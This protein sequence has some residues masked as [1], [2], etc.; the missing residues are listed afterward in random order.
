MPTKKSST[1]RKTAKPTAKGKGKRGNAKIP[2]AAG[3]QK[4]ARGRRVAAQPVRTEFP[5]TVAQLVNRYHQEVCRGGD[6][7]VVAYSRPQLISQLVK[8]SHGD[9]RIYVEIGLL[10][11]AMDPEI[12]GRFIVW[13]KARGSVRDAEVAFPVLALRGLTREDFA[14]AENAVAHLMQLSPIDLL[15]AYQLNKEL[16]AAGARITGGWRKEL[17]EPAL[18]RYLQA[19]EASQNWWD[20]TALQF[21]DELRKLYRIAHLQPSPRAKAILFENSVPA[22]SV[23]AALRGLKDMPPEDAAGAILKH[24]I[25]LQ[26]AMGAL[27]RNLADPT[28]VFALIRGMTHNQLVNNAVLLEKMGVG[29]NPL[30]TAA[31]ENAL[32][33]AIS[34]KG[35][36]SSGKVNT[37]KA[38][39]AAELV[40]DSRIASKLVT[41]QQKSTER[42]GG[43]EGDWL[44]LVD[45]SQSMQH[46]IGVGTEFGALIA[47]R[48]KGKVQLIFFNHDIMPVDITGLTLDQ[49]KRKV[50]KVIAVGGTNIGKG[51][52][53]LMSKGEPV[54]GI[55]I[56]SDGGD[57]GAAGPYMG[58]QT[59]P[60]FPYVYKDYCE[61]LGISPTVY[62]I[63][64]RGSDEDYL[65]RFCRDAGVELTA[66]YDLTDGNFGRDSLMGILPTLKTGRFGILDEL[67]ACELLTLDEVF[68]PREED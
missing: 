24:R 49:V 51:L 9:L 8:L 17:F 35:R 30:L 20:R 36:K 7:P 54:G 34:G 56:I 28:V 1:A 16:S 10:G 40:K 59:D 65:S 38:A 61:K 26:M 13:N 63:K 42:A 15:R 11:A 6:R 64:L 32:E 39:A 46:A 22:G 68:Q 3:K 29:K 23:F 4:V 60:F 33:A 31:Y 62:F 14:L 44:V 37:L 12:L 47:E 50:G 55:V 5:Y 19:R 53:Y 48:V 67:L 27:Q 18:R 58:Q 52:S 43:I 2:S 66:T 41:L 21:R 25:P 45:K 57:N